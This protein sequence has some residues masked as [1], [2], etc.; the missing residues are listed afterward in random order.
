[1]AV[2]WAEY[3]RAAV[4]LEWGESDDVSVVQNE[5]L[6]IVRQAVQQM[7]PGI[8]LF[9]LGISARAQTLVMGCLPP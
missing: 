2:L 7:C 8:V 4:Y 5:A 3:Q 1:M 6:G 9:L